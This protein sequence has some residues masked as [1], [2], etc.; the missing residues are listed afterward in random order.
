MKKTNVCELANKEVENIVSGIEKGEI[1]TL[2]E[3]HEYLE[4]IYNWKM[5]DAIESVI[6]VYMMVNNIDMEWENETTETA[7]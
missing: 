6:S 7:E 4:S 1:K 2:K 3:Y 5:I